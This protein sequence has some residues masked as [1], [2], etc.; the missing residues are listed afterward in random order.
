MSAAYSDGRFRLLGATQCTLSQ[1]Y[2]PMSQDSGQL[3]YPRFHWPTSGWW[4]T[5]LGVVLSLGSFIFPPVAGA[6]LWSR[7]C[8]SLTVVVIPPL[9][10]AA[11]Y[12]AKAA[13]VFCRRAL[14]YGGNMR[15]ISLLQERIEVA[16]CTVVG[17]VAERQA[18]T[19]LTIDYCY[20]SGE[21]VIIALRKKPGPALRCGA[22]VAVIDL[23][24]GSVMG[25]FKMV[26]ERDGRY[27]CRLDG[28]MDALW[29]G[30]IKQH[31][32]Q[33]SE[34]PLDAIALAFVPTVG[35]GDD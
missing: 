28:Y 19:P 2:R 15:K 10:I 3:D 25:S 7:A 5:V 9:V 17:L 21:Q 31:G 26:R 11:L 16:Q 6:S 30:D 12:C 23:Q 14:C 34:A 27:L 33:R 8:F 35:D 13:K 32:S 29:L 18:R 20:T 4:F 1:R 24:T 22:G